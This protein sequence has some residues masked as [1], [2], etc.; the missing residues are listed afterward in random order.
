MILG[1]IL[2]FCGVILF[3]CVVTT[4]IFNKTIFPLEIIT[5][6]KLKKHIIKNGL[7]KKGWE[8]HEVSSPSMCYKGNGWWSSYVGLRKINEPYIWTNSTPWFNPKKKIL[9]NFDPWYNGESSD[10]LVSGDEQ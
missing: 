5:S 6:F 10:A 8:I 7:V 3:A 9:K 1:F 4:L 2:F